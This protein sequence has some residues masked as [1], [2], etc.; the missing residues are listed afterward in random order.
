MAHTYTLA[1]QLK[2]L[3]TALNTRLYFDKSFIYMLIYIH[4]AASV[5]EN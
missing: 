4:F 5:M 1:V 2:L 3:N